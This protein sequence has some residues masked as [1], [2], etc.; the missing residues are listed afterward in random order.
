[1]VGNHLDQ[2]AASP[3]RELALD[4][5]DLSVGYAVGKSLVTAVRGFSLQVRDGEFVGLAGESGCGKSTVAK[6]ILRLLPPPAVI[7]GGVVRVAGSDT[8]SADRVEIRKLR[9]KVASIVPQN[10]LATLNPVQRI[11]TQIGEAMRRTE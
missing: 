9:W 5:C 4:I 8:M 11:D 1:M 3:S 6:A 2:D 7:T 10:A